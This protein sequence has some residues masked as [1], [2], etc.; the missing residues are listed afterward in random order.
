MFAMMFVC[1]GVRAF[2]QQNVTHQRYLLIVP[3]SYIF[4][5]VDLFVLFHGLNSFQHAPIMTGFVVGTAAWMG[6]WAAIQ[7]H[8]RI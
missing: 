8:K 6:A 7:L 2:Q 5:F 3:T 4:S 1:V